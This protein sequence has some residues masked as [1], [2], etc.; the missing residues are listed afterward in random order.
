MDRKLICKSLWFKRELI[1]AFDQGVLEHIQHGRELTTK[2]AQ[3]Y[4]EKVINFYT[5]KGDNNEKR[6][7]I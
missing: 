7:P 2:A 4:A 1:R 5:K 6:R 3:E